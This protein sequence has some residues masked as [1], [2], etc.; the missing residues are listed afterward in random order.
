MNYTYK[1]PKPSVTVDCVVFGLDDAQKLKVLLIQRGIAP[2]EDGWALPGG[3]IRL[4]ESIEAAA[5]RELK[6]ET[7]I[8]KVFLEQLYTFG[9]VDRDPRDRIITVA[10]YALINIGEYIIKA[11]TDA[12]NVEWFAVEELPNL[13]FDHHQILNVAKQRLKGKLRYQPIG[14]ELLPTKFTLTQLQKLY[15]TVLEQKLDKRNFRNKILK[16]KLLVD[17]EEMQAGVS[18]RPAKLYQFD[19]QRYQELEQAGFNFEI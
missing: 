10:Y 6:E 3:F 12:K 5:A 16:M 18:H 1:Y 11:Q 17:T 13:A 8:E 14:F 9:E 19:Y 7:G 15:E 2:Y 4:D